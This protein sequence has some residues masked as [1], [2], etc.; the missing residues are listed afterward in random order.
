MEGCRGSMGERCRDYEAQIGRYKLDRG[1]VKN[2]I[3]NR[4][5]KELIFM[6][7]GHELREGLLEG[8]EKEQEIEN[9]F[10][11]NNEKKLP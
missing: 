8:E 9:L 2:S 7:H 5:A 1:N 4:E 3:G 6:T 11:K 10:E